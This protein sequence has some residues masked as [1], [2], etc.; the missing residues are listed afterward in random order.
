MELQMDLMIKNKQ[1][2]DSPKN[3][4]KLNPEENQK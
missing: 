2:E 1:N 3:T 4:K